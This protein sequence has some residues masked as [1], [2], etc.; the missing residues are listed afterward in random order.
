MRDKP[1]HMTANEDIRDSLFGF[2]TIIYSDATYYYICRADAGARLTDDAWSIKRIEK[3]SP[4]QMTYA[5]GRVTY[6]NSVGNLATVQSYI[7]F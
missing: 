4:Y 2:A 6:D 3:A 5:R 7:Y 1:H